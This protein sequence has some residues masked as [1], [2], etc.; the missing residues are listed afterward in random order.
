MALVQSIVFACIVFFPCE[1]SG[2]FALFWYTYFQTTLIGI[3]EPL[4]LG[5]PIFRV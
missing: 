4:S 5:P 3:R 1:F 2:S